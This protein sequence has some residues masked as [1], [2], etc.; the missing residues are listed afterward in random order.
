[1]IQ[2]LLGVLKYTQILSQHHGTW[3]AWMSIVSYSIFGQTKFYIKMKSCVELMC[4]NLCFHLASS[5]YF[6]FIQFYF[7]MQHEFLHR[8]IY[9]YVASFFYWEEK[10]QN[11]SFAPCTNHQDLFRLKEP[12]INKAYR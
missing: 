5:G 1:M 9:K 2:T 11:I 8:W 10:K 4:V 7:R 6:I 3:L 12:D